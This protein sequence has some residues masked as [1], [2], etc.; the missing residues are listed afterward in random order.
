MTPL[1]LVEARQRLERLIVLGVLVEDADAGRDGLVDVA[2]VSFEQPRHPP[3]QL[4]PSRRVARQLDPLAQDLDPLA[5]LRARLEDLIE[6]VDRR[7]LLRIGLQD[8]AQGRDRGV[9]VA[10]RLLLRPA[11]RNSSFLRAAARRPSRP[12]GAGS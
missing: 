8:R 10:E 1:L 9:V 6:G 2:D 7:P 4:L 12:G 11:M 3:P 5:V